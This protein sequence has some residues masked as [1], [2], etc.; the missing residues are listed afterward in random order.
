MTSNEL[1]R[2]KFPIGKFIRP[3]HIDESQIKEWI[4]I[5]EEFPE[6]IKNLTN[7]LSLEEKQWRYRPQGWN[8]KE[9]VHHCF[10][11]HING[12]IRFKLTLTEDE[13]TIKPYQEHLWVQLTDA[14]DDDLSNTIMLLIGLHGRWVKLLKGLSKEDLER[15]FIHPEESEKISL[16]EGMAI[17]AWHC[18]H[19]LGHIKQALEVK[20]KYNN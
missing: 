17:Y 3:S 19:H 20:G 9:V 12:T 6:K 10:D 14:Q 11:S 2:L 16:K 7:N 5:I 13:P 8:I 18:E 1:E 15:K 4:K